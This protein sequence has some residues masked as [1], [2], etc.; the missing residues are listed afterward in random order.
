MDKARLAIGLVFIA[1]IGSGIVAGVFFAFSSFVMAA[2]ARI[3]P[4]QAVA[5]MNSINITVI[6][7]GFMIAFV[8]TAVLCLAVG[9]RSAFT[10][11]DGGAGLI[12]L[13]SLVYL[14]GCFGVTM[15][16][17]V[18]L[19]DQLASI[20]GPA[21]AT[22]FWPRYLKTW[23]MWNHLRTIAAA[24]SAVLFTAALCRR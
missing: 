19:N 10:W 5:A 9:V 15:L 14:L 7:P 20:T 24:L 1:A 2:L 12:F 3:S 17:N 22:A 8:G 13:A 18:P 23:T 4:P 21:A 6:N 11:N 16:L